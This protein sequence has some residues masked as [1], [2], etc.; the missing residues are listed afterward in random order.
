MLSL[1]RQYP[2][3][4]SILGGLSNLNSRNSS[5]SCVSP[6]YCFIFCPPIP[7]FFSG[8]FPGLGQFPS[9]HT[10]TQP[11]TWNDSSAHSSL[12]VQLSPLT[13]SIPHILAMLTSQNSSSFSLTQLGLG[14]LS[15]HFSLV[16]LSRQKSGAIIVFP[17]FVLISQG[18]LLYAGCCPMSE[19]HCFISFSSGFFNWLKLKHSSLAVSGE[20]KHELNT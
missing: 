16:T 20:I 6:G 18:S 4:D 2:P 7:L 13:H 15:L 11:K 5:Q 1:L 14:F 9:A 8:F 12:S 3:E 17:L 19:N 10:S